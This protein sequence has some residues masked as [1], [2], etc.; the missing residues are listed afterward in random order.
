MKHLLRI[1]FFAACIIL[2]ASV[3]LVPA[4]SY[5]QPPNDLC[6]NAITIQSNGVTCVTP[7]VGT[8]VAATYSGPTVCAGVTPVY[9]VWYR[10]VAQSATP[11]VTISGAGANFITPRVQILSGTCGAPTSVGC[12]AGS[13]TAAGLTVGTAYLIRV[14][15]QNGTSPLTLG[16]FSICITDPMPNVCA[17]ATL[18]FSGLTCVNTRGTVANSTLDGSTACAGTERYDVWYRFV[19]N[20]SNPT[21]TLSNI[22]ANFLTPRI[23]VLSACGGTSLLCDG[24]SPVTVTGLSDG[25]TYWV[26]VYSITNPIPT[27]NANFDICITDPPPPSN[28]DCAGAFTMPT[29]ITC[30]KTF[31]NVY[32]STPSGVTTGTCAGVGG[33]DVWYK[34]VATATNPTINFADQGANFTNRRMQLFTGPCTGL[35]QVTGQCTTGNTL[36]PTLV[37]G[38]TYYI[39]LFSSSL[40]TPTTNGEFSLCVQDPLPPQRYGNSYVNISKRKSGGIVSPGDTLEIRM[41]INHTSGTV[42]QLRYLDSVP[43]KTAMLVTAADSI[44]IIT[45]EGLTYKRYTVNPGVNDDPAT[46]IASPPAGHHQIRMNV[47]FAGFPGTAPATNNVADLTGAVGRMTNT[48]R[49]A[50]GGGLLFAT[51]FRVKVTGAVGDTIRVPGGRFVFRTVAA[52]GTDVVLAGSP[53][54]IVISNPLNLCSN[55]TGVNDAEEFGGTFGSG[56]TPNRAADL[57]FPIPGYIKVS[58]GPLQGVGDGQYAIVKNLSPTGGTNKNAERTPTCPTAM[59]SINACGNRMHGGHW[60]IDGD[61]TN[62]I[63]SIGNPPPADAVAG[64]YMLM[65]N[66][67]YV[68]SETYRQ[69]LNNLCPNTYYEFSAWIRNVCPTCGIDSAGTTYTPRKPGVLPNLTFSLNN[70]D[71]YSTGEV[72]TGGWVKKGFVFITDSNQTSAT[73]SIR[74]NSQG[75]GG[76]DWV[77]DDIKVATCLPSMKYSPSLNPTV[78]EGTVI[79]LNDTV[80]SFFNNYRHHKWQRSTNGGGSWTDVTLPVDSTPRWNGTAWEYITTYTVPPAFTQLANDGDLYRLIVATTAANLSDLDCQVTDG[81]SIIDVNVIDCGIPL[82]TDLLSFNGR[83]VAAK[84]NLAWTTSKEDGPVRFNVE[85]STDGINYQLAGY[86]DS[87]NNYSS[88][89]NYYTFID[90]LPVTGKAYYRLKL[91]EQS[92]QKYSRTVQLYT[93]ETNSFNLANV[94]NP[95]NNTL[96]FDI[97]SPGDAKIDVELVDLFGKVVRRSTFMVHPGINVLSLTNTESLVTGTYIFRVKK[98]DVIINRKVLKK[99]F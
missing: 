57:T 67:D 39:R 3:F 44:R 79:T 98:N 88:E 78:C 38:T 14:Y 62:T 97:S 68:A 94:I 15:S 6:A 89:T 24:V 95:F 36:T 21:I 53:Y 40:V 70:V 63:N 29:H 48:N 86:V 71:R 8:V 16:A 1:Q 92:N 27:T 10:F 34:F 59:P 90:P 74:N 93:D 11:T 87:Y 30:S 82:K 13:Y 99:S 4:I 73:F 23:Q 43:S 66:A 56:S 49:P 54:Y 51:S 75:G 7:T 60:D 55:V 18:L 80:Q 22:G 26:R 12:A 17:N 61:H 50:G 20:S 96:D 69:T 9:D 25:T 91:V 81:V 37:V 19:A 84:A 31:G 77:I 58:S 5:A 47:G 42:Y 28:D 72:D 52:G 32:N 46:Y 65:V 76:N 64:G 35:T 85:R 2:F 33:Y 41:T 45:N 83:L